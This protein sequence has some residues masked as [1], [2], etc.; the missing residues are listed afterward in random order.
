[1]EVRSVS[2]SETTLWEWIIWKTPSGAIEY[3][4]EAA[5]SVVKWHQ[6]S[7]QMRVDG[8]WTCRPARPYGLCC[9]RDNDVAGHIGGTL[10]SRRTTGYALSTIDLCRLVRSQYYDRPYPA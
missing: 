7:R 1:M 2:G 4:L 5:F 10:S 8:Q 9:Y 3:S 6:L